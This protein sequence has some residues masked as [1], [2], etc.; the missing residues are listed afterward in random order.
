MTGDDELFPDLPTAKVVHISAGRRR[1]ERNKALLER[2]VHPITGTE[3][4][5]VSWRL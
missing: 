4:P 3:S 1:T 5:W 2:G